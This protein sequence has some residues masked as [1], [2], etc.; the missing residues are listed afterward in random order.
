MA[1]NIFEVRASACQH[2]PSQY[3]NLR[4]RVAS[5][6]LPLRRCWCLTLFVPL[7]EMDI[8]FRWRHPLLGG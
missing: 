1:K 4:V 3:S 6:N 7:V 2:S 5:I 8:D